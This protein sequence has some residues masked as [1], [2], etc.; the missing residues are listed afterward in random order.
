MVHCVHF[1][2]P[3]LLLHKKY[4]YD[5]LIALK[6][7]MYRLARSTEIHHIMSLLS[8]SFSFCQILAN[9]QPNYSPTCRLPGE[10]LTWLRR[11]RCFPPPL[12]LGDR[13]SGPGT[14]A[15]GSLWSHT[16]MLPELLMLCE[17]PKRERGGRDG[18]EESLLWTGNHWDTRW[19]NMPSFCQMCVMK[20]LSGCLHQSLWELIQN[21]QCNC[22]K[23][24]SCLKLHYDY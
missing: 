10:P 18:C 4:C 5:I 16:R 7:A 9:T 20:H 22:H 21:M 19:H 11:G 17:D 6:T 8:W 2:Y 23:F 24:R 14:E 12:H 15:L 1:V 3:W 13:Q